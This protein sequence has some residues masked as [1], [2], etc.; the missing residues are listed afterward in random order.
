M[1][2]MLLDIRNVG[3]TFRGRHQD[4]CALDEVSLSVDAGQFVGVQGPS[5]CGKTTLLLIAGGLLSPD[6]GEVVVEFQGLL[7]VLFR[8]V[9]VALH[10]QGQRQLEVGNGS[11][12]VS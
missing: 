10:L 7:Q 5:G 9:V 11:S 1:S 12:R 2:V 4:V 3:K 6:G 8:L